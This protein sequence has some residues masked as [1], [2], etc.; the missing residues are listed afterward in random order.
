MAGKIA[1]SIRNNILTGLA[2]VTPVVVTGFI[3]AWLFDFTT[4]RLIAF[5]PK[6]LL[7][8]YPEIL[9]RVAALVVVVVGLFLTGLLV[10]NL[11]GKKL[12]QLGDAILVR[13]PFVNKIYVS[14][15][16][17]SEAV[18]DQSQTMFQQV[19]LVEYP[20]PGLY[21]VGFITANVPRE[22]LPLAEK[23]QGFV[24]V[25][26]PTSPNPTSGWFTIVPRSDVHPMAISVADAMKLVVSGG[27]VFPGAPN[28][29]NRPTLLDKLEAWLAKDGRTDT[30]PAA[31]EETTARE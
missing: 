19:V 1:R 3:V 5:V 29:D 31:T 6:E 25:F 16:Q 8:Q 18:L 14:V 26:I 7:E 23:R 28:L 20:R 21:S 15:R 4:N 12:Y 30:K 24:A 11:L 22:M 10:R 17:I 13:T 27:A 9:F 2:L